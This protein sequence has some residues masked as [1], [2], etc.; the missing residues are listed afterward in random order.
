[1]NNANRIPPVSDDP[2]DVGQKY[3]VG[4]HRKI[5]LEQMGLDKSEMPANADDQIRMLKAYKME[6]PDLYKQLYDLYIRGVQPGSEKSIEQT[7]GEIENAK[8]AAISAINAQ[9]ENAMVEQEKWINDKLQI[10]NNKLSDRLVQIID[11]MQRRVDESVMEASKKVM[12][13]EHVV[14]IAEKPDVQLEDTLPEE[15]D[16]IVQLCANRVN[17]L[18]VG[19]SGCGKTHVSELIAKALGLTFHGQSCSAGMSESIF[20]G[21][22]LPIGDSGKF[23]YV[24]SPFVKCYEE[25]GVF[26]FDEI[27]AADGNTLLF[28]NQALANNHFFL[29]QRFDN[30]VVKRHPDF[31]AIAAANT[32]GAG[33]NSLYN[34]RNALDAAS[35]DRFRMGTVEMNYSEKVENALIDKDVLQIG[36]KIRNLINKRNM[37]KILS[38]RFMLDATKMRKAGWTMKQIFESYSKDWSVEEKKVLDSEIQQDVQKIDSR[39]TIEDEKDSVDSN[40]IPEIKLESVKFDGEIEIPS[41][42]QIP[43]EG[44]QNKQEVPSSSSNNKLIELI[45]NIK[46]AATSIEAMKKF[47]KT[48]GKD[49]P[50]S[51]MRKMKYEIAVS[52]FGPIEHWGYKIKFGHFLY[53]LPKPYMQNERKDVF[54]FLRDI[55]HPDFDERNCEY[56]Y[57]RADYIF[58]NQNFWPNSCTPV[59]GI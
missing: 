5:I 23:S 47:E 43:K 34:S 13:I 50:E 51:E 44:A 46:A 54:N 53:N 32:Y 36:R 7:S 29:P 35:M 58:R 28:L 18:L 16:K 41:K 37:R 4:R 48:M 3:M 59:K 52:K 45:M 9:V 14:K 56:D 26:L 24:S 19:P 17:V 40:N 57:S 39:P 8:R 30:T 10:A 55:G 42:K 12:K 6:K 20:A 21:W 15:F 27:D 33:A 25:G 22:L 38:T 11:K 1:M 31:I 2:S 49:I